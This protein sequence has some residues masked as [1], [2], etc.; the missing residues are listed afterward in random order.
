M[1]RWAAARRTV[2]VAEVMATGGRAVELGAMEAVAAMVV[3]TAVGVAAVR[4]PGAWARAVV[5]GGRREALREAVA[6]GVGRMAAAA[7]GEAMRAMGHLATAVK[8]VVAAGPRVAAGR[9]AVARAVV[10]RVVAVMAVGVSVV[11][12]WEVEAPATAAMVEAT[13][14]AVVAA[15][16]AATVEMVVVAKVEQR[17]AVKVA[18]ESR[19]AP[20]SSLGL[21]P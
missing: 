14:V 8:T 4:A 12:A 13:T 9:A 7:R 18:V 17:E 15:K 3:G 20:P 10:V 16:V 21:R 5:L 19:R 2:G 11:G 1:A 6:E